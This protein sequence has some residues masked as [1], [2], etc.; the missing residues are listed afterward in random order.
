ML[1]YI[2]GDI[3]NEPLM[4]MLI[5]LATAISSNEINNYLERLNFKEFSDLFKDDNFSDS[6]ARIL[7]FE[8]S[9][10][11]GYNFFPLSNLI[12]ALYN[13]YHRKRK[14]EYI[15]DKGEFLLIDDAMREERTAFLERTHNPSINYFVGYY[16]EG[17]PI[18]IWFTFDG[19]TLDIKDEDIRAIPN[20]S[21]TEVIDKV[22]TIINDIINGVDGY[23]YSDNFYRILNSRAMKNILMEH[24]MEKSKAKL[25]RINDNN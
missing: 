15:I 18:V 2:N 3:M 11:K 12:I 5:Y 24:F 13:W 17:K 14:M 1:I 22:L 9:Y 16:E 10:C 4:T 8:M 25:K 6:S 7:S 21:S 19:M 23:I 20:L